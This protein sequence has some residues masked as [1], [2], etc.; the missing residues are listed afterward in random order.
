MNVNC[1]THGPDDTTTTT[2][3]AQCSAVQH[4]TAQQRQTL[5]NQVIDVGPAQRTHHSEE[6]RHRDSRLRVPAPCRSGSSIQMQVGIQG[7]CERKSQ[8]INAPPSCTKLR[9]PSYLPACLPAC[10]CLQ[11]ATNCSRAP[12]NV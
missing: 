1:M 8:L 3:T 12:S 2:C 7:E 9:L 10:L 6:E 11:V 4:S 5:R